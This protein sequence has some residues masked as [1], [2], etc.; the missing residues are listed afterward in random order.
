MLAC[1]FSSLPFAWLTYLLFDVCAS[2]HRLCKSQSRYH[3]A[4]DGFL[5]AAET[6][7][8]VEALPANLLTAVHS[9]LATSSDAQA[10][11]T[12]D[13]QQ[14]QQQQDPRKFARS[15]VELEYSTQVDQH[16]HN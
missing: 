16:I 10:A 15:P 14:Q 12:T 5:F 7:K 4:R 3:S 6:R 8:V 9:V 2:A 1:T 11:A 13:Q